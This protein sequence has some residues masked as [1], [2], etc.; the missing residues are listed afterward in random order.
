MASIKKLYTTEASEDGVDVPIGEVGEEASG[1]IRIRGAD[2]VHVRNAVESAN[3]KMYKRIRAID[4]NI[5]DENRDDFIEKHKADCR[6]ESI[7][8]I[9]KSWT[10][11]EEFC[12]KE[13]MEFVKQSPSLAEGLMSISEDNARFFMMRR[14]AS[15]NG[16]AQSKG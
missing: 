5:P 13:I 2:S 4:K 11:D 1:S 3:R 7:V 9:F 6:Q 12:E 8:S 10:F 14:E 15:E 16:S